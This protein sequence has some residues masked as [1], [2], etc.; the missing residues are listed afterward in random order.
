[1]AAD[2][3]LCS[4]APL[5]AGAVSLKEEGG[6][7]FA[8]ASTRVHFFD[9]QLL[10]DAWGSDAHT[11]RQA[12]DAGARRPG[13]L[14]ATLRALAIALR[15]G[16]GTPCA[17]ETLALCRRLVTGEAPNVL[18]VLCVLR[19]HTVPPRSTVGVPGMQIPTN[20]PNH[21]RDWDIPRTSWGMWSSA[22]G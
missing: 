12:G 18:R 22:A 11:A 19:S 3:V 7:H 17:D 5:A 13:P 15:S 4:G 2:D 1:M 20:S 9:F 21:V 16:S 8:I 10:R 14:P 6:G